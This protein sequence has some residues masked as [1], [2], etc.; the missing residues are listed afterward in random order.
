[1]LVT[2]CCSRTHLSAEPS[3]GTFCHIVPVAPAAS[4]QDTHRC[5][6]WYSLLLCGTHSRHLRHAL[7][8]GTGLRGCEVTCP[9]GCI[10]PPH[11]FCKCSP[12]K[13]G[14]HTHTRPCQAIAILACAPC[15]D[16][17][18][19]SNA[20]LS[21]AVSAAVLQQPCGCCVA[22]WHLEIA[23]QCMSCVALV[24]CALLLLFD[25][26][27]VC[28]G[29]TSF[30]VSAGLLERHCLGVCWVCTVGSSRRHPVCD[31]RG[32]PQTHASTYSCAVSTCSRI[33]DRPSC[34]LQDGT[35]TSC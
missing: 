1:M 23:A 11:L 28:R 16:F 24:F 17:D 15:I 26:A 12:L 22:C 34:L 30:R 32:C 3:T 5:R 8:Q 29:Q 10:P 20:A 4:S 6:R 21:A 27:L 18:P 25:V 33:F 13:W 2:L 9:D 19:G 35:V 31:P 7:L 14:T